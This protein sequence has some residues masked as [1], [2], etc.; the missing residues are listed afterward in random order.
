MGLGPL[1]SYSSLKAM[2]EH[3]QEQQR[4]G[5]L[6]SL[7]P[8]ITEH[9]VILLSLPFPGN[10][11][12]TLASG[13]Q[14]PEYQWMV[15]GTSSWSADG[16]SCLLL[17]QCLPLPRGLMLVMLQIAVLTAPAGLVLSHVSSVIVLIVPGLTMR[18]LRM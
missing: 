8:P 14:D 15:W 1:K 17:L 12:F 13:P 5:T 4:L 3:E 10:E 11:G 2:L 7:L 18:V 6:G 9:L 16:L